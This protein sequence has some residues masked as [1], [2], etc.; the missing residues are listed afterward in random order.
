MQCFVQFTPWNPA[1]Q[2]KM[3]H[4][5]KL[6]FLFDLSVLIVNFL[7]LCYTGVYFNKIHYS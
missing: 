4:R 3:K 5:N 7:L 2:S 6:L 1:G